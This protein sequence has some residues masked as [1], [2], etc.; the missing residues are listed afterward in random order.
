MAESTRRK[1]LGDTCQRDERSFG[2]INKMEQF[3]VEEPV[4]AVEMRPLESQMG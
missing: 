1:W 3:I 2:M 4:R